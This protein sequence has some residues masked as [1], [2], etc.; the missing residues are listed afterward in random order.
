MNT[1]SVTLPIVGMHCAS[2]SS[3]IERF[4]KKSI[5]IVSAQVN[6]ATEKATVEYDPATT[7]VSNIASIVDQAGYK[8]LVSDTSSEIDHQQLAKMA[9]IRHLR[10]RLIVAGIAGVIIMSGLLKNGWLQLLLATVI[11]FWV[12]KDF[13]L[14]TWASLKNRSANMDTLIT[15]GTTVAYVYS[16]IVV[17]GGLVQD[18]YFDTGVVI[19]GLILLGKY[20]EARAKGKTSE[21]IKKLIGLQPKT[22]RVLRNGQEFD[23]PISE[24]IIGDQIRLRPGEK[25]PVDGKIISGETSIDESMVT[26]ESIPV[27]KHEADYVIAGTLNTSGSVL[28]EATQIGSQ[29][30]L[31]QI[32]KLVEQ[33]QASRAPIQKL[34]DVISSYFV[35]VVLMIAIATFGLWYVFGA[36]TAALL[37]AVAVLIIACPCALGLATPTALVVGT[38]LAAQTG[39]LIKDAE[40]LEIAHQINHVLFDKT[41]TLTEGK[42]K[43]TDIISIP[44]SQS[45]NTNILEIAASLEKGSEHPLA[46]AILEAA[47]KSAVSTVPV[48]GFKSLAGRG[49]TGKIGDIEYILGNPQMFE[50]V[51]ADVEELENQGKTVVLV[52]TKSKI[53]GIIAIADTVRESAKAAISE[54]NRLGIETSLVTGDNQRTAQAISSQLGM[55]RV[56]AQV[57]PADKEKIVRQLQNEGKIV[58]MIGDGVNDAPALSAANIG[59]AMATGTDVAI[60][61]AGITLVN[62]DLR[63]I[64]KALKLSRLTLRTIKTNLFW[65]FAYNVILIPAAAIGWMSP[66]WASLA[67]AFSSVSVV[68]NSLL[69]KRSRI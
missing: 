51:P 21:A 49:V 56:F 43:V 50:K 6:Y 36:P 26:G 4:L 64:A 54:L 1:K 39:I 10:N 32:I 69:L 19:I 7:S 29:T 61:A 20:L 5:G 55:K 63:T 25:V 45:S 67:M 18:T 17:I 13:Y 23:L 9:E 38:G 8:A 59:I 52:G 24:V 60:E 62:K 14:S 27:Y 42:P 31:A 15:L 11:Q 46:S 34:A 58:A 33:A 37:A 12:G 3:N 35:P 48:V 41:G 66:M 28:I 40:S 65:A 16:A 2:C 30:M 68:G 47:S 57:M 53:L 44:K 22:A